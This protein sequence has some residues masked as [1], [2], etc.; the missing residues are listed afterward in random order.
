MWKTGNSDRLQLPKPTPRLSIV[1]LPLANLSS[2]PEQKYLAEALTNGLTAD[3]SRIANGFVISRTTAATYAGKL[4]DI[5]QIGRELGVRYVLEGSIR[6]LGDQVQVNVQMIDA[7]SGTHEWADRFEIDRRNLAIAQRNASA[8]LAWSLHLELLAAVN[9]QIE[10]E[11]SANLDAG[12]LVLRGWALWATRPETQAQL[13][14]MR[15]TFERALE[16]EPQSV[17]ARVGIATAI[18]EEVQVGW[19]TSRESALERAEQ[20]LTEALERD[21]NH[22]RWHFA[23]GLLRRMQLRFVESKLEFE[24]TAALDPNYAGA[25]LQLSCTQKLVTA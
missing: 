16:L 10:T 24:R 1:V 5:K 17:D 11:N 22:V 13:Q 14:D 8:R 6:R 12:D 4:V 21:R 9:R 7:E 3:L 25:L 2:D 19:S 23:M 20:L 15:R 18:V